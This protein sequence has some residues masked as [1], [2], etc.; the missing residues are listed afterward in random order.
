ML[1]VSYYAV[2]TNLKG[3]EKDFQSH[4]MTT[5]SQMPPG[6][7]RSCAVVKDFL[8]FKPP[9]TSSPYAT[10]DAT[11]PFSV[12]STS[13][14]P[15]MK[16]SSQQARKQATQQQLLAPSLSASQRS[17]GIST[18]PRYVRPSYQPVATYHKDKSK[19]TRA[20]PY[21]RSGSS[22]LSTDL[23]ST[24]TAARSRSSV[25]C[26]SHRCPKSF[27]SVSNRNKHMREGCAFRD[28]KG[29]PCRNNL[30][31]KVLTTKWYRKT[32]EQTRCRFR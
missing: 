12:P 6:Y 7:A 2:L 22:F 17:S 8:E 30:C 19:L 5:V 21:A 18:S 9:H 3:L 20:L 25:R 24:D 14:L 1:S 16:A 31:T 23:S 28:K 13:L 32:H 4:P 27:S 15:L 10:T 29:Y 11:V 26:L